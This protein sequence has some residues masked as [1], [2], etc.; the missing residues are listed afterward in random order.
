MCTNPFKNFL[1]IRN[2]SH[3]RVENFYLILSDLLIGLEFVTQNP[4][5]T[6]HYGNGE[7]RKLVQQ[8]PFYIGYQT[9]DTIC[10]TR[11]SGYKQ[12]RFIRS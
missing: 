7:D 11:K 1:D 5:N 4:K 3:A 10:F 2:V 9:P 8:L 6:I 12:Y